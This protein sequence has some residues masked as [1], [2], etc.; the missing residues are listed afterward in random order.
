MRPIVTAAGVG[1]VVLISALTCQANQRHFSY[2]YESA[3]LTPGDREMELWSTYRTGRHD[4]YTEM[5]HRAEFEFGLTDRLMTAF[6]LNWQD[7]ASQDNTTT[8]PSIKK[9][10]Q[11]EGISSEWKYKLTD[12]VADA[13]GS[14]LYGEFSVA[15]DEVGFEGKVILDKRVGQNLFAYNLSLE[16]E[17]ARQVD[18]SLGAP[19]TSWENNL[20]MTHFFNPQTAAGLELRSLTQFT[21]ENHPD[22]SALYLGPVVSYAT[23]NWW[24]AA[25]LL[26]ELPALKRSVSDPTSSLVLDEQ[27]RYAFRL[28]LSFHL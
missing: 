24:I 20:A 10:S 27:E 3:V 4:Y 28:L 19:S 1:L 13:F 12:P 26:G 15:T 11:W 14:A 18:G 8:P 23:D 21:P 7:V 6:Y 25:T 16:P 9:E 17:W 5:D 22:Y 2:T